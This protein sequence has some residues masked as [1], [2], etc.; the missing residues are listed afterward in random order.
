LLIGAKNKD[1]IAGG[2][3]RD[4]IRALDRKRDF[5]NCG[6]GKDRA[7]VDRADRVKGCEK[8]KRGRRR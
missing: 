7:V 2:S 8:V 1:R 6:R 4:R 5:V 3:G